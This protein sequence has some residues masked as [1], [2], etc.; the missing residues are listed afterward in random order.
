MPSVQQAA[1]SVAEVDNEE[2]PQISLRDFETRREEIKQQL[3]D[4]ASNIGFL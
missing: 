3:I 2:V 4:A 1:V